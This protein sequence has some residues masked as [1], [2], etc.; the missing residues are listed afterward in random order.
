MTAQHTKKE[1]LKDSSCIVPAHTTECHKLSGVLGTFTAK[2]MADASPHQVV[3][4][5]S[6]LN[7]NYTRRAQLVISYCLLAS[8][9]RMQQHKCA[10]L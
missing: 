4:A 1:H 7:M 9:E 8:Q 5:A 3:F 6:Q 10:R 2:D